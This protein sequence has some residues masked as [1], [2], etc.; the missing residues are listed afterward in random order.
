MS[1]HVWL[2]MSDQQT[3]FLRKW[4]TKT[5]KPKAIIHIIHGMAEHSGRYHQ[6]A[7][8][9]N[10]HGI[11]V[12]AHDQRGHG[13]TG[14]KM[15]IMGFFSENEGF[16]RVVDDVN[17]INAFIRSEAP[18]LPIIMLGHSM[19]SFVTRRFIQRYSNQVDAV[20]L[21]GTAGDPGVLGA[22]GRWIARWQKKRY[23]SK[24][25]S[26]LLHKLTF[27]QYNKGITEIK[28]DYDWLSSDPSAVQT[29]IDDPFCGHIATAGFYDDLLTGLARIHRLR[30]M[31][32]IN[33]NLPLFF[34]SGE[35]DPV[36]KHGKGVTAVINSYRKMGVKRIDCQLYANGR[37]EML[38]ELNRDQVMQAIL[39]WCKTIIFN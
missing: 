3:I 4:T 35:R 26:P 5:T 38:F 22:F 19:G 34:I 15:G 39:D 1:K 12:Y 31:E 32:K 14:E 25:P 21:S 18:N 29:Y 33:R 11:L 24:H 2:T 27:G 20:I 7:H 9:L 13:Q 8:F 17:E 37:H 16:E 23:G 30:E 6:F 10:H 36:G 28:S